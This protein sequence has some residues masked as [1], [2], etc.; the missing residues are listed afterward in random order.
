MD[1]IELYVT[2]VDVGQS[3]VDLGVPEE[4]IILVL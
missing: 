3:L 4:D 2:D 1:K